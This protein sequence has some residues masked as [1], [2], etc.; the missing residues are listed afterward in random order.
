M[1]G[2]VCVCMCVCVCVCVC[3]CT[4][5]FPEFICVSTPFVC[6][7]LSILCVCVCVFVCVCV[8]VCVCVSVCVSIPRWRWRVMRSLSAVWG[9]AVSARSERGGGT[10]HSASAGRGCECV[11][12]G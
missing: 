2:G 11:V 1:T 10:S 12:V 4:H 8:C 9:G 5:A 6:M 7:V 3:V